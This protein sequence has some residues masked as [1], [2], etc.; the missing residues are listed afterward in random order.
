[1][2]PPL[3]LGSI[4]GGAALIGASAVG[5][6][7]FALHAVSPPPPAPR[8]VAETISP[9]ASAPPAQ[10]SPLPEPARQRPVHIRTHRRLCPV[11]AVYHSR[12]RLRSVEPTRLRVVRSGYPAPPMYA[13]PVAAYP[14]PYWRAGWPGPGWRGRRWRG[15]EWRYPPRWAYGPRPGYGPGW[16]DW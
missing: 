4:I 9:V 7:Y 11:P 6:T 14:S 13:P 3:V 12:R 8:P 1:M 16:R 2:K 15:P 10:E 5:M